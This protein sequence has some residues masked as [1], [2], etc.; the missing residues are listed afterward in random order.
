MT[1]IYT[2]EQ[3]GVA[4]RL[5]KTLVE[6]SRSMLF[7]AGLDKIYWGEAINTANYLKNMLP[8]KI[9]TKTPYEIWND[10]KPNFEHLKIFGSKA[11]VHV[12]KQQRKKLDFKSEC[13]VFVGY[14]DV[15]KGYRLLNL[16]TSG[17]IIRR[18][19]DF[20][21]KLTVNQSNIELTRDNNTECNDEVEVIL[22]FN[23]NNKIERN[24]D[25]AESD[26]YD[27][28]RDSSK[29]ESDKTSSSDE[30]DKTNDKNTGDENESVQFE[31]VSYDDDLVPK[32]Y[33]EFL[34][35]REKRHWMDAMSH[36]MNQMKKYEVWNLVKPPEDVNIIESKWVYRRKV[37]LN[38]SDVI[39]RAR[40]V[41]K[42]YSQKF[43]VDYDAVFAPVVKQTTF[44]ILLSICS[45]LNLR[46]YQY[47]VKTAFLNGV[48]ENKIYMR[49]PQG[50]EVDDEGFVCELYK[51][52]Y[53]LKQSARMWNDKINEVILE[54][55]LIRSNYDSCL[56][57]S[58]TPEFVLYVDD[59]LI[60]CSDF[61]ER[62]KLEEV[63]KLNF[64][65]K[66]LGEL[67]LFLGIEVT[68]STEG[69]Y[70][71]CQKEYIK[72]LLVE[73]NLEN[74]KTSSYPLDV[75]YFTN[76][77]NIM[78]ENPK[79][80]QKAIGSL[81]YLSINTRPDIAISVLILGRSVSKPLNKDWVEVKRT[82]K[83]LKETMDLKLT[84]TALSNFE[85]C[86]Y[87]DADWGNDARDRKSNT[88]CVII[89]NGTVVGWF[90]KKQTCI[91]LSSTEAEYI[92]L[93]ESAREFKWVQYLLHEVYKIE[94]SNI[95]E[96]NQSTIKLIE[97]EMT[98]SRTKHIDIQYHFV[99]QFI[100]DNEVNLLYVKSED[101][102]ADMMT[103]PFSAEKLKLFRKLVNLN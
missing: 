23:K 98:G 14:S 63:L 19:D 1:A 47:D 7:D 86:A 84:F 81:L 29:N 51:S 77:S 25:D 45:E 28:E 30:N 31:K 92:V 102:I 76:S 40:L 6:M 68:R 66:C 20:D 38:V 43:G 21:E 60:A 34:K 89:F 2:P 91:A 48:L 74:S 70:Q 16:E 95:Y 36:E 8:T 58:K 71:I 99:R 49:Q 65:I 24:L 5:N 79:V 94:T 12:P 56:Y 90:S 22:N 61:E 101:N 4:E 69:Y 52:K 87:V 54:T 39:Y 37:Q 75:G 83:Y 55:G 17:V 53:G 50:F 67:S 46:L 11:F 85:L 93:A 18:D 9:L 26:F 57:Y 33:E 32:S 59:I 88:G 42:G 15:T 44:R 100:K 72:K 62:Q 13:Y 80:Y 97:G 41:A 96:D 82:L 73:F 78:F 3:N 64:E 35:S 10:R 27:A 103:K